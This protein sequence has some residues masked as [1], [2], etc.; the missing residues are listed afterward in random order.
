M[1]FT[2]VYVFDVASGEI[3]FR[4]TGQRNDVLSAVAWSP[5]N[6]GMLII[7]LFLPHVNNKKISDGK[8]I[9]AGGMKGLFYQVIIIAQL[10]ILR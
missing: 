3:D 2:Q 6:F 5:G 10:S 4:I 1:V 7:K 8:N 9:I